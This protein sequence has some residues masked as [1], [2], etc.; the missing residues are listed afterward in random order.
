MDSQEFI[1]SGKIEAYVMGLCS[2][3]ER[4]EVEELRLTHPEINQAVSLFETALEKQFLA[5]STQTGDALDRKILQSLAALQTPVVPIQQ[6]KIKNSNW[7]KPVAA[8][9]I[10]LFA[11]SSIFNYTLY[12]KTKEQQ[13]VLAQKQKEISLPPADYSILKNPTITPVAMYGVGLH[14]ICRCT[15][16]WDKKTGKAY[17]MIHHLIPSSPNN[18]YQLWANVNGQPVS[19]GIINDKIRDRFIEVTNVPKEAT[20][21]SVTLEK[22]GGNNTP[23]VDQTYLIGNI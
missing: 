7:L 9:A 5:T 6:A 4:V 1:K 17:I 20:G 11:A 13:E 2:T 8:A 21:F 18:N 19:V 23:T 22:S 10:V 16:F 15:M 14:A 12:N 3:E